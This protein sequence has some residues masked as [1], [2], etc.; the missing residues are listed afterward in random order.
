M[1]AFVYGTLLFPEVCQKIVGEILIGTPATLLGYRRYEARTRQRGNYPAIVP[2]AQASVDG[3][4]YFD[5]TEQQAK[6]LDQFE[7]IEGQL[8]HRHGASVVVSGLVVDVQIY[9]AGPELYRRLQEPLQNA[10]H[11]L[12]FQSQELE[13]YLGNELSD[14]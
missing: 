9:V 2:D 10:W 12:V 11:P 4:V 14:D 13:W 1:N 3:L 8:Y 7:W 6:S 5:I